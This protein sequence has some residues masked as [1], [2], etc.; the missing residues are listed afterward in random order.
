MAKKK[1]NLSDK[2]RGKNKSGSFK[3]FNPFE[4]KVNKQKHHVLGKKRTKSEHG[5]PGISKSKA[6]KKRAG[7]LLKEYQGRHKVNKLIDKRIGEKDQNL[8]LEEKMMQRY[9]LE[10]KN[11]EKKG[12]IYS[13]NEDEDLTHYG[14]SLS[15]IEKFDNPVVSDEDEDDD[16]IKRLKAKIVAEEHF[17]GFL[18]KKS[19]EETQKS[20][21]EKMEEVIAL[22]KKYKS[23]RQ[24]EKNE[25]LEMTEQVDKE[26]KEVMDLLCGLSRPPKSSDKKGEKEAAVTTKVDDYDIAVRT[27]QFEAKG[28]ASDRL[29]TDEEIAKEEK[30]RLEKLEADRL[31]R[32]KGII[33]EE[34][35]SEPRHISADDLFDG[36]NLNIDKRDKQRAKQ[37]V[38]FKDGKL[39]GGDDVLIPKMKQGMKSIEMND[40]ESD[41]EEEDEEIDES[42]DDDDENEDNDDE[43]ENEDID[44]KD[45]IKRDDEDDEDDEEDDSDSDDSYA[46]LE[47]EEEEEKKEDSMSEKKALIKSILKKSENKSLKSRNPKETK[48]IIEKAKKELPYTFPAPTSYDDWLN[49]IQGLNTTDQVTVVERILKLYHPSLGEGNKQKLQ[50]FHGF[51]VQYFGDLALQEPPELELMDK[52]VLPIYSL[53]KM[54]PDNAA[55]I[56]QNEIMS[57]QEEFRQITERKH[58]RG[59]YLGLDTLLMLKVVSIIFPTSDFQHKVTTPSLL[60]MAQMLG[61]TP[62]NSERDIIY[63]LYIC[64]LCLEF[65]GM[66]K[67]FIPEVIS[68]LHGLLF[69]AAKKN[70]K[71]LEKVFPPFKPVGDNINLL[72]MKPPNISKLKVGKLNGCVLLASSATRDS[73]NNNQIRLNAV[74]TT[75]ELLLEYANL[76]TD[77]PAFKDIFSPVVNMCC[78]LP[79]DMYPADLQEKISKLQSVLKDRFSKPQKAL[80]VQKNKP[81]ALKMFEPQIEEKWTGKR[82]KCGGTKEFQQ[83]QKLVHKHKR[84]MK[85]AV[86]DIRRDSQFLARHQLK[87]TLQRDSDRKRKVKALYSSLANQEGE[88]RA[89]TKMKKKK[90]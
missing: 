81:I 46:D 19:D 55:E 90:Y 72:N 53:T 86:R 69:L 82:K 2:I 33:E 3:K 87:E 9:A 74:S 60:F 76:F 43:E 54:S 27:L 4:V 12:S 51:L 32:M 5:A 45:D 61:Q 14:Q 68:F 66:S 29:K 41:D 34:N 13:L 38:H 59:L 47:S 84:E 11:E 42:N 40:D 37:S 63:G 28:K 36:F 7:T 89:L 6:M 64:N 10:R 62:V 52:L 1:K 24:S 49:L 67:R 71:Q 79:K 75:V 18:T 20:F 88:V 16:D 70:A 78:K 21:K 83:T 39:A 31:M 15:N 26:Y 22:S 30:E 85:G 23:E 35:T 65:I 58:G 77:L 48:E 80:Q 25:R 50:T 17:G 56:F 73:L 44:N 8:T 57:R